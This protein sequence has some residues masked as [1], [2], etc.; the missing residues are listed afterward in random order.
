MKSY[1]GIF[2]KFKLI[3][4]A[5]K[6][7]SLSRCLTR[8]LGG[9]S[10]RTPNSTGW[11]VLTDLDDMFEVF[12]FFW[13]ELG[14]LVLHVALGFH[15]DAGP[16]LL[17]SW[18]RRICPGRLRKW[19]SRRTLTLKHHLRS[20]NIPKQFLLVSEGYLARVV[21]IT[22]VNFMKFAKFFGQGGAFCFRCGWW[23]LW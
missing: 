19:I 21:N 15:P 12:M 4:L 13:R 5:F 23:W 10:S 16:V 22:D 6:M 8:L 17:C 14:C 9:C 3:S 2:F 1:Q 18:A 20:L 7:C 11:S